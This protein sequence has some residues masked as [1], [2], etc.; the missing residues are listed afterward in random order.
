MRERGSERERERGREGERERERER[1]RKYRRVNRADK[2]A[3]SVQPLERPPVQ[4]VSGFRF[5][6]QGLVKV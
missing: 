4:S 6:V 1:A 2:G 5:P 3:V